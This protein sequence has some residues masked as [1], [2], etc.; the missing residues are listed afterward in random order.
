MDYP[1]PMLLVACVY[2][3]WVTHTDGSRSRSVV[4]AECMTPV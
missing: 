4:F 2:R 3:V 1:G